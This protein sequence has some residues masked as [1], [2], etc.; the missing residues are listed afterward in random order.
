M[1]RTLR[2]VAGMFIGA[3]V[4]GSLVL[5]FLPQ[6]GAETR[7]QIEGRIATIKAEGRE[8]AEARRLELTAQFEALK[9]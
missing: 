8:A 3:A 5:L 1:N 4:A 6:S 7:R 2:F 9:K